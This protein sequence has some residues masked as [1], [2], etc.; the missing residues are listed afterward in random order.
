MS[1]SGPPSGQ[2]LRDVGEFRPTLAR[3]IS[4]QLSLTITQASVP[5]V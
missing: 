4:V 2:T 5:S 3:Q 1:P